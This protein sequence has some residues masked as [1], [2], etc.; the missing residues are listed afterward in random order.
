[1]S[2]QMTWL[3]TGEDGPLLLLAHG[4]GAPMD[5]DFMKRL[6][7]ALTSVGVRVWRFEF[8]YMAQRRLDGRKRPPPA[9][10]KL[11][12][13]W[14]ARMA[15]ASRSVQ[16]FF[17]GGKSL[18]GRMASH[19]I[20]G[21]NPRPVRGCLCFGYPFRPPAKLDSWR[22]GHFAGLRQPTWIA[23]GERDAF[24]GREAVQRHRG[25][26]AEPGGNPELYWVADGNHDFVPRKRSGL[27]WA[28]NLEQAAASAAAFM[29]R[30]S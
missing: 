14:D 6:S 10:P 30:H 13:E 28:A 25:A 12:E 9:A 11:L 22:T 26:L 19:C 5:S 23:Q 16:S 2:E 4:A 29:H 8:S 27:T 15:E 3:K 24:G 17:I 7:D 1:M 20:A 21:D 18:G